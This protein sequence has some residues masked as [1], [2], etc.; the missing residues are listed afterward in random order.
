MKSKELKNTGRKTSS[1]KLVYPVIPLR[2][3]VVFPDMTMPLFIGRKATLIAVEKS[4]AFDR[5]IAVV[6]Q[7]EASKNN[8]TKNDIYKIG[9]LGN[10]LQI[11][12]LPNSNIKILFEAQKRIKLMNFSFFQDSY[13][14]EIKILSSVTNLNKESKELIRTILHSIPDYLSKKQ[15]LQDILNL[16]DKLQKNPSQ[17]CDFLVSVL[18][19]NFIKKQAILEELDTTKRL[20]LVFESLVEEQESRKID[21]KIKDRIQGQIGKTHKEFYLQEQMKAI[22]KELGAGSEKDEFSYEE[23]IKKAKLPKNVEDIVRKEI[24]RL[25]SMPPVSSESNLIRSYIDWILQV[26]WSVKSK[27]NYNLNNASKILNS[28]HHGLDKIKERI[29]EFIAVTKMVGKIKGP[30]LC[31]VGPPGVGKSSLARAVAEALNR[32][33]IRISLGGVRD[34]A[35]IRG[36]RRTYIGAMPGKIIQAMKKASTINPLILLDEV[37]KISYSN[38]GDPSAALL[39]VLDPEQNNTF[40]D[41]YL[42]IEYDLSKILFFCTANDI[43]SI[44]YPLQDRMEVIHLSGYTEEEKVHIFRKHLLRKQI[45]EN[46]LNKDN[47]SLNTSA[48][49]EIIQSYTKEAGIREL[50]RCLGKICRKVVSQLV[51]NKKENSK[52]TITNKK[53]KTMLGVSK[54]SFGNKRDKNLIG[55]VTGLAWTVYGGELLDIE[56]SC[57]KGKGDIHLTG[58]LGEVMRESARAAFSFVK[59][60]ANKLGIYSDIFQGLDIHVHLPEGAIPKDGP[61]AG[62]ALTTALVSN[63]TGIPVRHDIAMTGEISLHGR[64]LEIGGLKQKLLAA[65]RSGICDVIIPENNKKH[66]DEIPKEVLQEIK[67]TPVWNVWSV[68]EL[69]LERMPL[70]VSDDDLKKEDWKKEISNV[71]K[72]SSVLENI[73]NKKLI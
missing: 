48:I 72:K 21:Q 8:P 67:I 26:P 44:P 69:A 33:F 70:A 65:K 41:H 9:T 22:Q 39:E 66:L 47:I 68:L 73:P 14:S 37:D 60:N 55:I 25:N 43:Q 35:E 19:I 61:S 50:E 31:L 4:L 58:K 38:M 12:R 24:K 71:L 11:M 27:D 2:D 46:G 3:L 18:N 16:L 20:E 28:H 64:V 10:I 17:F 45:K 1:D 6:A 57:M 30:I 23:K 15:K 5:K 7:K 56:V 59:T 62:I 51:Q 54:Y 49:L 53:V 52:F 36:H 34:E 40:M 32:K 29:L 42:D 63:L 13:Q